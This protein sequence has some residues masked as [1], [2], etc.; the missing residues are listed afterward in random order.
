LTEVLSFDASYIAPR[1]DLALVLAVS[2]RPSLALAGYQDAI[3]L[4]KNKTS[5]L[6][7]P[8]ILHVAAVDLE[9]ELN[10][11]SYLRETPELE[12]VL[13]LIRTECETARAAAQPLLAQLNR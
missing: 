7:R 3:N 1:F 4:A 11:R 8:A 6:V 2:K 10:A 5:I 12:Q 13:N 9:R